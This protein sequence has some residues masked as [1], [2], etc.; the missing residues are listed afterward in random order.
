MK[1][2]NRL[3]DMAFGSMADSSRSRQ[4]QGVS[5]PGSGMFTQV[6]SLRGQQSTLI[7]ERGMPA[8]K[9]LDLVTEILTR[10]DL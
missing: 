5:T 9:K 1:N 8:L 7:G 2:R 3:T 10:E 4:G 6:E